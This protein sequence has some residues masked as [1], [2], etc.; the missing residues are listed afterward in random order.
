MKTPPI[1]LQ[2]V[3]QL[4]SNLDGILKGILYPEK[5]PTGHRKFFD[6][7]IAAKVENDEGRADSDE[8]IKHRISFSRVPKKEA[9]ERAYIQ[10]LGMTLH[11][12][13]HFQND[14]AWYYYAQSRYY[15]GLVDAWEVAFRE[16]EAQEQTRE[17]RST[18]GRKKAANQTGAMKDEFIRI[19]E[20]PPKGG[21]IS[22]NQL[23]KVAEP[24]LQAFHNAIGA[25]LPLPENILP[26]A[27]RWL[28]HDPR[29]SS[30]FVNN[31]QDSN[32]AIEVIFEKGSD[33]SY[34]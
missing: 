8:S 13:E 9:Y 1:E 31:S 23:L 2:F 24:K 27:T 15:K 5:N 29:I 21:W 10:Y 32:E 4:P 7:V 3:N 11:Y 30:A 20:S 33:P 6:A 12:H 19:I 18:G 16:V 28:K 22:K 34:I 14:A 25:E 26:S 17:K